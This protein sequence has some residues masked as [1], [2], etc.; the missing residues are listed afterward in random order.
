MADGLRRSRGC[1]PGLRTLSQGDLPCVSIVQSLGRNNDSPRFRRVFESASCRPQVSGHTDDPT[2]SPLLTE[3]RGAARRRT[4]ESSSDFNENL[5]PAETVS[6]IAKLYCFHAL[7]VLCQKTRTRTA[8]NCPF[9]ACAHSKTPPG[10]GRARVCGRLRVV[11]LPVQ[12]SSSRNRAC[13]CTRR[14]GPT[15]C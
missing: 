7:F 12:S 5:G 15:R 1:R 2:F 3:S 4:W 13:C 11:D 9:C 6:S 14:F 8:I 10:P